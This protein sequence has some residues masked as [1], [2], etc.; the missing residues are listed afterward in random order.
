[1]FTPNKPNYGPFHA[2]DAGDDPTPKESL[3]NLLAAIP[4]PG[5]EVQSLTLP[6]L[7][8]LRYK[9][10]QVWHPDKMAGCNSATAGMQTFNAEWDRERVLHDAKQKR[11]RERGAAEGMNAAGK[12][13]RANGRGAES[14][15]D[16]QKKKEKEEEERKKKA[17]EALHQHKREEAQ[18]RKNAAQVKKEAWENLHPREK[19]A[20]LEHKAHLQNLNKKQ[21][22]RKAKMFKNSPQSGDKEPHSKRPR[23]E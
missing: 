18:K 10:A 8:K 14:H 12:G 22:K 16:A 9:F 11:D 20:Y 2:A 3:I 1:M 13:L 15:S 21:R 19:I 6:K 17:Q 4:V 5:N 7:T 23:H